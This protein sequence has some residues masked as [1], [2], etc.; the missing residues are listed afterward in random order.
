MR[1]EPHPAVPPDAITLRANANP[2]GFL[3]YIDP[4]PGCGIKDGFAALAIGFTAIGPLRV[5][6]FQAEVAGDQSTS[7]G[8]SVSN[9]AEDRFRASAN[10][11]S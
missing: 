3:S 9:S 4:T 7:I 6:L 11:A 1:H 10:T 5:W 8:S 2:A